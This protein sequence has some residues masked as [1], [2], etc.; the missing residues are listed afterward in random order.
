[1][2]D[3]LKGMTT[4]VYRVSEKEPRSAALGVGVGGAASIDAGVFPVIRSSGVSRW[5]IG[6]GVNARSDALVFVAPTASLL[7]GRPQWQKIGDWED[8]LNAASAFG[9]ALYVI[10]TRDSSNGRLLRIPLGG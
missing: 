2:K 4:F 3:P 10:T 8:R 9:D 5:S 6:L 1:G 7:D